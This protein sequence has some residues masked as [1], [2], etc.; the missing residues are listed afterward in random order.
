[1]GAHKEQEEK[2][3]VSAHENVW[4]AKRNKISQNYLLEKKILYLEVYH[5]VI[6]CHA[7]VVQYLRGMLPRRFRTCAVC[8]RR[9]P[10]TSEIRLT[11]LIAGLY[12]DF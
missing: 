4:N 7:V 3:G 12:A 1:M 6:S 9:L 5:E 8:R 11:T 10:Y 2:L